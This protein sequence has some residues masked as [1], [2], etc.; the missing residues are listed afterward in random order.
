MDDDEDIPERF[1]KDDPAEIPC[2]ECK[3]PVSELADRCQ[4][5]GHYIIRRSAA[6]A[7]PTW[8]VFTAIVLIVLLILGWVL[9]R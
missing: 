9:R 4:H 2:N 6:L 7:M 5:C 8:L 1:Q 3:R